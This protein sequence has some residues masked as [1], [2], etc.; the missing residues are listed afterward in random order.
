MST[1]TYDIL[2]ILCQIARPVAASL[3]AQL[4]QVITLLWP[5]WWLLIILILGVWIVFEIVT[6]FGTAH[7]NSENGFSPMFNRFVGSGSYLLVH[8]VLLLGL[9]KIFGSG[10][11]CGPTP[12]ALH[13]VAFGAV[14]LT[15]HLSGFWPYMVHPRQR[16]YRR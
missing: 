11:Y 2:N 16:R 15:L 4:W 10:V 6:R 5:W 8:A 13:V 1:S 9:S 12:Y 14:G 7:Y 3:E